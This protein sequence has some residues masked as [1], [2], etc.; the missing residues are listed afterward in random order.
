MA[1]RIRGGPTPTGVSGSGQVEQKGGEGSIRDQVDDSLFGKRKPQ[2][3]MDEDPEIEALLARL[4]VYRRRLVRL[5]QDK[6]DDYALVLTEGPIVTI[7]RDGEIFVGRAFLVNWA[8]SLDAQVGVLAHEIGHR[9][10]RWAELQTR[11]DLSRLEGEEMCRLEELRADTFTGYALSQFGLRYEPLFSYLEQVQSI[12][13]HQ[14]YFSVGLRQVTIQ[15]AFE[16]GL[17]QTTNMK[18]MFPEFARMTLSK[19]DLGEG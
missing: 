13:P 7:M 15:E 5:A 9:P 16:A 12:H 3:L 6:E 17:R 2:I 8:A 4:D 14:R 1:P 10:K 18:K 19:Y 11:E